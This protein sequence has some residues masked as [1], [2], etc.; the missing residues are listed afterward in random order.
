MSL[1]L[2]GVVASFTKEHE[3]QRRSQEQTISLKRSFNALVIEIYIFFIRHATHLAYKIIFNNQILTM[4]TCSLRSKQRF[5]NL[6]DLYPSNYILNIIVN[7]YALPC[8]IFSQVCPFL[9]N[10]WTFLHT[11]FVYCSGWSNIVLI[12]HDALLYR[13][14]LWY[15]AP[16]EQIKTWS[17]S[18]GT[19]I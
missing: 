17:S 16:S 10:I 4:S 5:W 8:L 3:G 9:H 19:F 2:S 6:N 12:T 7:E 18:R 13:R 1:F 11:P 14:G 15:R